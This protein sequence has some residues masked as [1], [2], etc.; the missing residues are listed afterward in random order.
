MKNK[1]YYGFNFQWMCST[2]HPVEDADTKALDFM[3]S[4]GLNFARIPTD[5]RFWTQGTDYLHPD[6][7]FMER[8]IGY[9]NECKKRNIHFCLDLHRAPGYCINSNNLETHNLWLDE[10]AQDGFVF[11][12]ETF[13]KMFKGIPAEEV[14]FDLL[15]EPPEIG[16]YG[17][18]REIHKR[19]ITRAA[20]A[21]LSVDPDR[22]IVIDGLCGGNIAMPEM[23][24]LNFIQ[25]TRG[26]QPMAL[27]HLGASW[28]AAV[29]D[30]KTASY[31]GTDWDE[32]RWD[33]AIL[34]SHYEPWFS[35]QKQG[36]RIHV[37]EF[38]CF[39]KVDNSDALRWFTDLFDLFYEWK[40]GY[41]MWNFKGPFGIIEHGRPNTEY[42]QMNGYSVDKALLD[43][44]LDHR[45]E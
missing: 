23:S 38:G 13:A 17:L 27:T 39:N 3:A 28:C 45:I 36:T 1:N 41:C 15:N 31:P 32:K 7:S 12:W 8:L 26:Y 40:W 6:K 29:Q 21:I 2:N 22:P 42:T 37:G 30:V 20:E 9:Y 44:F 19:I 43:L 35:L 4:L 24:D 34:A 33:K 11:I 14:S 10:I 18:T 5:Y 25:S 16:Q